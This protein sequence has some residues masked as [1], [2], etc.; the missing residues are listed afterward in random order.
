L[1]NFFRKFPDLVAAQ[2][3]KLQVLQKSDS[4]RNVCD[5]VASEVQAGQFCKPI[6][7]LKKKFNEIIF[8]NIERFKVT[9]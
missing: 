4:G 5:L 2:V 9:N 1:A 3:E 6:K 7:V 8:T